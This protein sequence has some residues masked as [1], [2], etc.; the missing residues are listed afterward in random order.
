MLSLKG[1][2][3]R[4]VKSSIEPPD[5]AAILEELIPARTTNMA[6]RWVV[7]M[8]SDPTKIINLS[9]HDGFKI[10]LS[11]SHEDDAPW[12]EPL[13]RFKLLFCASIVFWINEEGRLL[14]F[15]KPVLA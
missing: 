11:L 5:Q 12:I 3:A 7:P 4:M 10:F 1:T 13:D 8:E 14:S 15:E 2:R 9:H 6:T